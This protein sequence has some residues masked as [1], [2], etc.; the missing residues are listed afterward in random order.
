MSFSQE[1]CRV[2]DRSSGE[3]SIEVSFP[4]KRTYFSKGLNSFRGNVLV[5]KMQFT[6]KHEVLHLDF[7]PF[8]GN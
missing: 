8:P 2:T 6:L 4:T 1:S 7:K 5:F 3:F